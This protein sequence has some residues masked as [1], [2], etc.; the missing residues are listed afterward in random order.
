MTVE[1]MVPQTAGS[2]GSEHPAS[3]LHLRR[4]LCIP[5]AAMWRVLFSSFI[6]AR[7]AHT[8]T[9]RQTE[10]EREGQGDTIT[11]LT[12]NKSAR[13]HSACL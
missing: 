10:R 12:R 6:I 1:V 9:D 5:C 3:Y 2:T 13:P 8:E 7:Q 11:M 4:T